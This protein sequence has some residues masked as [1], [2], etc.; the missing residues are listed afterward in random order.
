M[1]PYNKVTSISYV[2][3]ANYVLEL[4][5]E[6][7][8]L[9]TLSSE[10]WRLF[11]CLHQ[12]SSCT[13]VPLAVPAP[14][15]AAPPV[16][17]RHSHLLHTPSPRL[18]RRL[19]LQRLEQWNTGPVHAPHHPPSWCSSSQRSTMAHQWQPLHSIR[20]HTPLQERGHAALLEHSPV[21]I[22]SLLI[23]EINTNTLMYVFF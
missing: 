3:D 20:M 5:F 4:N 19:P 21:S 7:P 10:V 16:G 18:Q 9:Q 6:S 15:L 23:C 1:Q 22:S 14:A 13:Q 17:T 8:D 11:L 12:A 2:N